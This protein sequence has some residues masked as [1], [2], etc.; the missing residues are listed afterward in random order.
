M[1]VTEEPTVTY[2]VR[3]DV[4][5]SSGWADITLRE[6]DGGGSFVCQSDYG[7]FAYVWGSIGDQ[8]LREFLC[9]L[10]KQYFFAK[11]R[12]SDYMVYSHKRTIEC[13]KGEILRARKEQELDAEQARECWNAAKHIDAM[14]TSEGIEFF[15]GVEESCLCETLYQCDLSYVEIRQEYNPMCDMF[16][17]R[18]WP[19]ITKHWKEQLREDD[20]LPVR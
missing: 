13:L 20:T 5:G 15:N 9:G 14:G 1:K 6:W 7:E 16:W 3:S 2:K 12:T 11:V 8:T 10:D 17:D 4:A 19:H 18:V